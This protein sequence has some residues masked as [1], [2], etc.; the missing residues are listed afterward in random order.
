MVVSL[1]SAVL[2]IAA[3]AVIITAAFIVTLLWYL[4]KLA[5]L[6]TT[7][8]RAMKERSERL[9]EGLRRTE[10]LAKTLLALFKL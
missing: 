7:E 3:I 10:R 1:P 6:V 9:R 5:R 2:Y 4:I 8:L